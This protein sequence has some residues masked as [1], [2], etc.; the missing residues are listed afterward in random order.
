MRQNSN[1]EINL[2]VDQRSNIGAPLGV[3]NGSGNF[4]TEEMVLGGVGGV[5]A[6]LIPEGN[7]VLKL[8]TMPNAFGIETKGVGHGMVEIL[9]QKDAPM[10]H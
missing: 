4:A 2:T 6:V 3:L 8:W 9:K 10:A 1:G 7:G 5:M